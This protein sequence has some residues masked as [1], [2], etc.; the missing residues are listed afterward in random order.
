MYLI[1]YRDENN[2]LQFADGSYMIPWGM[3]AELQNEIADG[4]LR[5]ALQTLGIAGGPWPS[6]ISAITTNVDPFTQ[7]EVVPPGAKGKDAAMSWL[8]YGWNLS[9]PTLFAVCLT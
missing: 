5:S 1:P 7:R 4:D 2:R 6:I 8:L 3:F 9:M